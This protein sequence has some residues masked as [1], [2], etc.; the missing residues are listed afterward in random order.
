MISSE[1]EN[2][3]IQS[4]FRPS[5]SAFQECILNKYVSQDW[6]HVRDVP[7]HVT[8]CTH[9]IFCFSG[10]A[11]MLAPIDRNDISLILVIMMRSDVYMSR[12]ST[13]SFDTRC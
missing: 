6:S 9:G 5:S 13:E 8:N 4:P 2:N 7:S 10:P 3:D 1:N 12:L 11:G